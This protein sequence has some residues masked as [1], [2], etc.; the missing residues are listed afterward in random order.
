MAQKILRLIGSR[1]GLAVIGI[2]LVMIIVGI[3]RAL[4]GT[5]PLDAVG[6]PPPPQLSAS[7][8]E[9]LGDDSIATSEPPPTPTAIP[10]AAA[11]EKVALDFANAWLK[12]TNVTSAQWVKGMEPFS[13]RRLQEQF[14]DADPTS[15]PADSV[16]GPVTIRARDGQ[17][18]E[19]DVPV[20]PGTLKLRILVSNGRWLVDGVS[21]VRP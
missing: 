8:S 13:T 12:S 19:A 1:Y 15:V 3:A 18:V 16:N 17:L 11:P 10:G 6:P 9:V 7:S 5:Q 14:K 2:V 20:N 4:S 21:W